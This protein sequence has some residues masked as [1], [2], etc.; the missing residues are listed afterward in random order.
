MAASGGVAPQARLPRRRGKTPGAVVNHSRNACSD[1]R[2]LNTANFSSLDRSSPALFNLASQPAPSTEGPKL[3]EQG[4]FNQLAKG[5]DPLDLLAVE[6]FGL[7]SGASQT[8]PTLELTTPDVN[9]RSPIARQWGLTVER[10]VLK[11]YIVSVAY[12]GT[13]GQKLFRVATPQ[14]GPQKAF[15]QFAKDI[16]PL[17]RGSDHS[18]VSSSGH[19]TALAFFGSPSASHTTR[20]DL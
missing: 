5:L 2:H 3:L 4:A 19:R 7:R 9:L 13:S 8:V 10:P 6:L 17:I 1:F 14:G 16:P 12:I 11:N 18:N 15:V 20:T